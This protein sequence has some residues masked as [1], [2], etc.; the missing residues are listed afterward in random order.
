MFNQSTQITNQ[1]LNTET[2]CR[3]ARELLDLPEL[4]KLKNIY[5]SGVSYSKLFEHFTVTRWEHSLHAAAQVA[6]LHNLKLPEYEKKVLQLALL[7]HDIGHGPGSH[8]LDGIFAELKT[9]PKIAQWGYDSKAYHEVHGAQIVGYGKNSL[10]IKSVLGE[11]LFGDLLAVLTASDWRTTERK[12]STYGAYTPTLKIETIQKLAKLKDWLDR[13]SYLELDF[14]SAGYIP[15]LVLHAL[16]TIREF[17][18]FT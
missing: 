8:A 6:E 12:I 10:H 4:L 9:A 16:E 3:E 1:L 11:N 5:N 15:E 7:F 18:K 14:K 13:T 17:K 2:L